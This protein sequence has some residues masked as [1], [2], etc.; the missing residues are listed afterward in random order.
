MS[1]CNLALQAHH[2][3]LSFWAGGSSNNAMFYLV[4]TILVV[5]G[6]G[7]FIA[8]FKTYREYRILEDTPEAPIRSIPMGLV[9]IHGRTTGENRL[10]SPLT[11]TP[12]YYYK[13]HVEKWVR[14]DKDREGWE[15]FSTSTEMRPFYA[16]DTTGKVLVD[17]THAEFDVPQTFQAEIGPRAAGKRFLEATL[18]VPGPTEQ[19]LRAY[20]SQS[21]QVAGQVLSSLPVPGARAAAKVLEFGQKLE[22]LGIEVSAGGVTLGGTAGH[23]YRFTEHCLIAERE[24]NITG[25]CVENP[26]PKDEHDRN[27][28]KKGQNEPTFLISSK[29]EKELEKSLWRKAFLMILLGAAMM[30]GFTAIILAKLGMFK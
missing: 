17:P 21:S 14:K 23:R 5:F 29:T 13:V 2:Y 24:Y 7:V 6:L 16:D 25:T 26:S 11:R 8:G 9:H 27:L 28:I 12:C 1:Y 15:T 20:L 30:I 18:G 3:A 22:S 10:T 19:D 4:M